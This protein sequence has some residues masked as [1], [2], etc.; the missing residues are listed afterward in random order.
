MSSDTGY[1]YF[2]ENVWK[3]REKAVQVQQLE[4]VC[5]VGEVCQQIRQENQVEE[6]KIHFHKVNFSCNWFDGKPTLFGMMTTEG[7]HFQ[8]YEDVDDRKMTYQEL[9][10]LVRE[11]FHVPD[12]A[13][14]DDVVVY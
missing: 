7:T 11:A 10:V 9:V 5:K 3:I 6:D 12:D 13:V 8:V 2:Y 14:F 1:M 4:D